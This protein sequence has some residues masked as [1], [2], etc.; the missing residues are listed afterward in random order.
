MAAKNLKLIIDFD[1]K[2]FMKEDY[3]LEIMT[4][5]FE[6]FRAGEEYVHDVIDC[7]SDSF[8]D[9]LVYDKV[10]GKWV[11]REVE[12]D[13][14][15]LI[16]MKNALYDFTVD[17]YTNVENRCAY[18]IRKYIPDGAY[19]DSIESLGCD[20][21]INVN[22]EDIDDTPGWDDSLPK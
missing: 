20:T 15:T 18:L 12:L 22:I 4:A 2:P 11:K 6:S 21:L 7:I 14:A 10:T 1:I 8:E 16:N 13:E 5:I 9:S 17:N 19:I 3:H